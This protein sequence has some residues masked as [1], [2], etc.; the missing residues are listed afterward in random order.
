M[1]I[2]DDIDGVAANAARE[3]GPISVEWSDAVAGS[4]G[5]DR[6]ARFYIKSRCPRPVSIGG[7][8]VSFSG[9]I[10]LGGN[11]DWVSALNAIGRVMAEAIS[12]ASRLLAVTRTAF[13][14]RT[15]AQD[16]A[17]AA[18][19]RLARVLHG[20]R[21]SGPA[22]VSVADDGSVW[23]QD[24]EKRDRGFGFRFDSLA[25]LW[26]AHPELRPVVWGADERGPYL[27]VEAVRLFEDAIEG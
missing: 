11:A 27:T 10:S 19:R 13:D 5:P 1:S 20:D 18:N 25:D 9:S 14:V 6:P 21:I 4:G 2:L 8:T 3:L 26:R 7:G 23:L 12:D 16:E 22:H 15:A 17:R 24:P